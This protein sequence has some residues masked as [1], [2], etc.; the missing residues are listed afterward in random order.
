M[1]ISANA[2]QPVVVASG[3][4]VVG[5]AAD[6]SDVGSGRFGLLKVGSVTN[7]GTKKLKQQLTNSILTG[8]NKH[9]Y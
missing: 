7:K 1:F 9:Q 2:V 5:V 3:C 6:G 4:V 8:A